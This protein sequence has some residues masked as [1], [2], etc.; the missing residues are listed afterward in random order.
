MELFIRVKNGQAFEH[1]IL[2]DNFRQ[3]FP[4]VSTSNLPPEFARFERVPAPPVGVYEKF[5]AA[6][7]DRGDGIYHDVWTVT[8]ITPEEKAAK[9]QTVKDAWAIGGYSSWSF[10]EATCSFTPPVEM[11]PDGKLYRWDE[12]TTSWIEVL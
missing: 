9:Q 2:G 6:Y 11:P 8:D 3:A 10:D 7:A 1:P 12:E 4:H 5:S